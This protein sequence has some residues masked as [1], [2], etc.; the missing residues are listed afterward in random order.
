M[1]TSCVSRVDLHRR[2]LS[3][4][5]LS[6]T[7]TESKVTWIGPVLTAAGV[8]DA[9]ILRHNKSVASYRPGEAQFPACG[10]CWD[11]K[12]HPENLLASDT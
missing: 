2:W 5:N 7:K 1:Q 11:P 12:W 8:C 4:L 6:T 10:V 9:G 3:P